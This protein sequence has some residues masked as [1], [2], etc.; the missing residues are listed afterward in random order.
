MSGVNAADAA[1]TGMSGAL[2]FGR[3]AFAPNRLGYC[4]PDD[5]QALFA[6]VAEG[7]TDRGLI[8]LERRFEGA[9]PYLRLI[10]EANNIADPFDR[11]V[12][13]AYWIGNEF[14][15]RVDASRFY[16]S[17]GERF[18]PR[19][20]AR[21]FHWLTG[22]LAHGAKPHHNFHVFDV[23]MRAGLMNDA[24]ATIAVEAMDSCRISWGQVRAINGPEL[25][26]ARPRL[27]LR[28]GKLALTEPETVRVTRQID[29]RG[30]ADEAQPG[31]YV[32]V[33][34]SWACEVLSAAA[35]RRLI[36]ATTRYIALANETL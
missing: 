36:G 31:D 23:Y 8:D 12:V 32:S 29:G 26:I 2:L 24:R 15:E 11:R 28:E 3:Y 33:H 13:E 10:A 35:L 27:T 5:A 30:F 6:Y 20:D 17:L 34:W 1:A 16:V 22:K 18:K 7:R 9:Y 14:L 25:V 4:G 21:A 19:M